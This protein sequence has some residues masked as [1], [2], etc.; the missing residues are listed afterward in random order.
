MCVYLPEFHLCLWCLNTPSSSLQSVFCPH[1]TQLCRAGEMFLMCA[2]HGG[3][4]TAH[5][6]LSALSA[7]AQQTCP[8]QLT[9]V[10]VQGNL[11]AALWIYYQGLEEYYLVLV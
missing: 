9:C 3:G 7:L 8:V 5:E 11:S 6:I 2:E 4:S 1:A 10:A